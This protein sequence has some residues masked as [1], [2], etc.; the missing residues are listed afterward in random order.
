MMFP[1][2]EKNM[3][4]KKQ[5]AY[6]MGCCVEMKPVGPNDI[7]NGKEK[8]VHIRYGQL[9]VHSMYFLKKVH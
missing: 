2:P 7:E 3:G 6:R 9:A 4:G 5:P 8:C 1:E